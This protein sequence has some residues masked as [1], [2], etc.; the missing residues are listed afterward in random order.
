MVSPPRDFES[1]ASTSFATSAFQMRV[2]MLAKKLRIASINQKL[3]V[4]ILLML[5]DTLDIINTYSKGVLRKHN[6]KELSIV[7]AMPM[8]TSF[9]ESVITNIVQGLPL[10]EKVAIAILED[11]GRTRE[12]GFSCFSLKKF[13]ETTVLVGGNLP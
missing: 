2:S 4:F 1:R 11:M 10:G 3:Y 5:R 9:L 7:S 8:V 13:N 12:T 6:A